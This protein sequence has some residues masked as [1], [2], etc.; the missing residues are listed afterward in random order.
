MDKWEL[1]GIFTVK[2]GPQ[3]Q[4]ALFF[5]AGPGPMIAI[6]LHPRWTM[7]DARGLARAINRC[8]DRLTV[9]LTP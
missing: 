7:E 8:T 6:H 3:G 5:E 9:R 1:D 2:E 4:L